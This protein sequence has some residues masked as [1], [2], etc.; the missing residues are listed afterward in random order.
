MIIQHVFTTCVV[1]IA[2]L[3]HLNVDQIFLLFLMELLLSINVPPAIVKFANSLHVN[4]N[5]LQLINVV[6]HLNFVPFMNLS[7]NDLISLYGQLVLCL[8]LI[9]N[10]NRYHQQMFLYQVLQI[11]IFNFHQFLI[12]IIAIQIHQLFLL[13]HQILHHFQRPLLHPLLQILLHDLKFYL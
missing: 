3:H 1:T 11:A 10:Q 5:F 8:I 2:I 12:N 4:V 7:I 13:L 6:Y 9:R